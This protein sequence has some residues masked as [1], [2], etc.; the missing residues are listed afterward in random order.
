M[1][2]P[3]RRWERA[4]LALEVDQD[5]LRLTG[6]GV[7][8]EAPLRLDLA[9][10]FR[11]GA[12]AQV[13]ERATIAVPRAEPPTLAAFGLDVAGFMEGAATGLDLRYERRRSARGR[14][15][16]AASCARRG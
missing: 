5:G 3:A 6:Q 10:D 4:A 8:A 2:S 14:S 11:A 13:T 16:S 15:R 7:M 1:W 9:M 12:P